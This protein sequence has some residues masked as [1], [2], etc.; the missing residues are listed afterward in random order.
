MYRTFWHEKRLNKKLFY[1][2]KYV[3]AINAKRDDEF[4][5]ARGYISERWQVRKRRGG[6]M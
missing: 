2:K 6:L 4:E 1:L 5:R 3:T